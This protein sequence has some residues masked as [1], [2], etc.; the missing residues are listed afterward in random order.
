MI[1]GNRE[2]ELRELLRITTNIFALVDSERSGENAK[3]SPDREAFWKVCKSVG[4]DCHL[5]ERRSLENYFPAGAIEAVYGQSSAALGPFES[6]KS[7]SNWMKS[8]NWRIAQAMRREDL[9][10]SDLEKFFERL[11]KSVAAAK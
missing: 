6:V 3:L 2:D 5:T 1:N 8:E 10:G 7:K 4:I 9:A 11:Q